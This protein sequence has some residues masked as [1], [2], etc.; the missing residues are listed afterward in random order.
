MF[1]TMGDV[2]GTVCRRLSN[3]SNYSYEL[4][5][6]Q[7]ND[8]GNASIESD[9]YDLRVSGCGGKEWQDVYMSALQK[10]RKV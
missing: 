6:L 10:A 7:V 9:N 4:R 3:F 2:D 5:I 1:L 8:G